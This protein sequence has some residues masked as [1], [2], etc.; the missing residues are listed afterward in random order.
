[1]RKGRGTGRGGE[2]EEEE[3]N[4]HVCKNCSITPTITGGVMRE[5]KGTGEGERGDG[6]GE[7]EE[8]E[9]Q[10]V[11]FVIMLNVKCGL[12]PTIFPHGYAFDWD[13]SWTVRT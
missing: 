5:G 4:Q 3:D 10:H 1:M 13:H 9:K 8:E 6:E 7:G 11:T 2:G 12:V